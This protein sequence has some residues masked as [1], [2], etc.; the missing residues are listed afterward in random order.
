[1]IKTRSF[2]NKF[3][4]IQYSL[5]LAENNGLILEFGVFEGTSINFNSSNIRKRFF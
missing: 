5:D 1:M 4:L 3:N 2:E